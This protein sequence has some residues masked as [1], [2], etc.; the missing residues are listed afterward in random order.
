MDIQG[1]GVA[2]VTPFDD[3]GQI[4]E[5][6]LVNILNH[7]VAGEV[8]YVVMLGTTGESVTLSKE[9]KKRVLAITR[10]TVQNQV[11][12]V[13]GIGGNNT[14][15]VEQQMAA[16]DL[17]GC[18]AILS[19]APYYNKPTQDGL[20]AH[21]RTLANNAPLPLILYNVPGR[22]G[23]NMESTTTLQLSEHPNIQGIKEASGDFQQVMNI[24]E[25]KPADFQLVSG[26]DDL[27]LP[28]LS[29]GME[30]VISVS[31]NAY[32]ATMAKMVRVARQGDFQTARNLHYQL[33]P[34]MRYAFAEG[35]PGGVKAFLSAMG[36]CREVLRL[37]LVP[38]SDS[39]RTQIKQYI[40]QSD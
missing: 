33:L 27:T 15:E 18:S 19:V 26:D 39:L 28:L 2:V 9:E 1:T 13:V 3:Q 22:T 11:S 36:F 38:V 4:D 30:G 20:L 34:V 10:S 23:K 7:L 40:N 16:L 21:F 25:H 6:A 32:P 14:R 5:P 17:E 12:V 29:V 37:P 24:I 8:S 35:N 31:A